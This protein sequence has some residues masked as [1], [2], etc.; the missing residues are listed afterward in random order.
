MQIADV[1]HRRE[2]MDST[3]A[4]YDSYRQSH[5]E[6]KGLSTYTE[7]IQTSKLISRQICPEFAYSLYYVH[8]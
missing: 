5:I 4:W 6:L 1:Q 7:F 2:L 8:N 3:K